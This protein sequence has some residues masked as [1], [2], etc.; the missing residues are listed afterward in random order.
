MNSKKPIGIYCIILMKVIENIGVAVKQHINFK[1]IW[2]R[3]IAVEW[4]RASKRLKDW[5]SV[6]SAGD[7]WIVLSIIVDV[8]CGVDVQSLVRFVCDFDCVG[9]I[10]IVLPVHAPGRPEGIEVFPQIVFELQLI[11]S[12]HRHLLII[13]S[14]CTGSRLLGL[15][16]ASSHG[17]HRQK[18]CRIIELHSLSFFCKMFL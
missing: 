1:H 18:F 3:S 15:Y 5:L 8:E 2:S 9:A 6:D 7:L 11:A 4:A 14:D 10:R 12:D 16:H 13:A 17:D